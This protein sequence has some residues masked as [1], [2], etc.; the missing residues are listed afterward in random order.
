MDLVFRARLPAF[1]RQPTAM[2]T[3]ARARD[4]QACWAMLG[5]L[6]CAHAGLARWPTTRAKP[7][8][9]SPAASPCSPPQTA[10]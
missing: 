3:A 4:G 10:G 5:Q 7:I 9:Q 6:N 1:S 2:F 8:A